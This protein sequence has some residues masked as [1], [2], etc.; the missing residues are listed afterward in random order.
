[1]K[2]KKFE[3]P[4]ELNP[5]PK[6]IKLEQDDKILPDNVDGTKNCSVI[7]T[8]LEKNLADHHSKDK[9]ISKTN[10]NIGS[11]TSGTEISTKDQ[12]PNK[13]EE[14]VE[15]DT[16]MIPN[17]ESNIDLNDYVSKGQNQVP[18]LIEKM[19]NSKEIKKEPQDEII[20]N[21][22][23]NSILSSSIT[24]SQMENDEEQSPN[25][26]KNSEIFS[27]NFSNLNDK[28]EIEETPLVKQP[29]TKVEILFKDNVY[30]IRISKNSI[31]L[32]DIRK[33]L[34]SQPE[35]FGM[36]HNVNYDF[37][38]KT[39]E[40]GKIVIDEIDDDMNEDNLPLLDGKIVLNCWAT[41]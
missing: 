5:K 16:G 25:S 31:T 10:N 3:N 26:V 11:P 20:N 6:K 17:L 7:I 24:G 29:K 41:S 40:N 12:S 28:N 15:Q 21:K 36:S 23:E 27:Q 22:S 37:S 4:H 18:E 14:K 30:R 35:K 13:Y 34:M 33:H 32:D 19:P 1:M 9:E 8:N 2:R 38:V 39:I